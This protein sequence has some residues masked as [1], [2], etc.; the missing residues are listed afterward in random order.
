MYELQMNRMETKLFS[1]FRLTLF[2]LVAE[3]VC[4]G[5]SCLVGTWTSL[6]CPGS[7]TAGYMSS[8][9]GKKESGK[10]THKIIC[11]HKLIQILTLA[12]TGCFPGWFIRWWW[13]FG[14]PERTEY[15]CQCI[16]LCWFGNDSPGSGDC[17]CGNRWKGI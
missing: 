2:R 6:Q 8:S 13:L 17:I 11:L 1:L 15:I 14:C 12:D 5:K 4:S 16:P 9:L 10:F 3:S 7:A